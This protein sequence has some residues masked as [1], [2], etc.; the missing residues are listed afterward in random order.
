MARDGLRDVFAVPK[1][2]RVEATWWICQ[3][4]IGAYR[5]RDRTRGSEL[6]HAVIGDWLVPP[7]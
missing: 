2:V 6:M 3:R 7:S 4:M 1:Q 5:D